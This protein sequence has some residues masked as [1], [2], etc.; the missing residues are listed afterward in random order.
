MTNT[1]R[2]TDFD[3]YE[4]H[5]CAYVACEYDQRFGYYLY[6]PQEFWT[7]SKSDFTLC[8]LIHGSTREPSR[9]RDSFR[10]FCDSYRCVV[11][12]PLFP[13]RIAD[14]GEVSNYKFIRSQS[15]RY[16]LLLLAMIA[17]VAERYGVVVDKFLLHGFSGG[18][19]FAHRF[20][21]L[22]PNRILG[23]SIGAPGMVTLLDDT[24]DWHCG[25]RNFE[26]V[27][28]QNIDV[29]LLRKTPVHMVI[30]EADSD[31]EEIN[32]TPDS[33]LW[34]DGVNDAGRTRLERMRSLKQSFETVGIQVNQ[35][36]VPGIEHQG[37]EL[38][39]SVQAFFAGILSSNGR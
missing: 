5:N 21:Y 34:M 19:H 39:G 7:G 3:R 15:I 29:D 35:D 26:E 10:D 13:G 8:V 22:H 1:S 28:E 23:L 38:V 32:I 12:A 4:Q 18:G 36:T 24:R 31:T 27:F 20:F 30:G 37:C 9:D 11:L 16:D 17:E 33:P 2:R 14:G 6:I 25:V